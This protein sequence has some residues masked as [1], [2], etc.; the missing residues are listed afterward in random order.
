MYSRF[1]TPISTRSVSMFAYRDQSSASRFCRC[2]VITANDSATPRHVGGDAHQGRHRER[3][4]DA[5]YH[6][7]GDPVADQVFPLLGA[8]REHHRIA[9]LEP[10]HDPALSG[11]AHF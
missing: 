9:A 6:F 2:P 5:G 3:R 4:G 8:A 10:H 11:I 7:Y 1:S